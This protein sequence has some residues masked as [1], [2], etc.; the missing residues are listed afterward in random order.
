VALEIETRKV[1]IPRLGASIGVHIQGQRGNPVVLMSHSILSSSSMWVE[2]STLLASKGYQ[3]IRLDT[4]GH[5]AS[6]ALNPPY[7]MTDLV[8]DTID[9]MDDLEIN[10]A[11]YVGLSLG[12]MTGFGL[13]L[14]HAQRFYQFIICD[15]RADAPPAFAA[16][17]DERMVIAKEQGCVALAQ[18]TI[19]RWFGKDFVTSQSAIT[20]KLIAIAA[21]TS[22]DGFVGCAKAIQGLDYLTQLPSISA[23]IT[24]VVGS[25]DGPLPQAMADIAQ[26]ISGSNLV[27]IEGAG[28]LPNIDQKDQFD[29]VLLNA[30]NSF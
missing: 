19:E 17:W 25:K 20:N 9:V 28:H 18:S 29:V 11:H 13:A 12:G 26:Q 27:T 2:Q 8:E 1:F 23:P 4:R 7:S 14:N 22:V 16:P 6:D 24:L 30:L 5:G 3:A 21:S 15:A 10:K